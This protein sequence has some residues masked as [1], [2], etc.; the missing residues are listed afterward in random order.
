MATQWISPTWRM[1]ENSNQSKFENY[2]LSFDGANDYIQAATSSDAIIDFTNPWS[3]SWWAKWDYSPGFDCFWQFGSTTSPAR[4]ILAWAHSTGIGWSISNSAS[5]PIYYNIANGINDGNWHNIIFTGNGNTLVADPGRLNVYVDG[6]LNTDTPLETG[7]TSFSSTMNNI[8][9]GANTTNRYFNGSM[10]QLAIFDY[11]LG[12]DQV[13]DL[14]AS[15]TPVN[16]MSIAPSPIAYYPLGGGST[17]DAASSPSTLTVPNESVP[18]A[19]VFDFDGTNDFITIP[20]L[21]LGTTFTLS[22]WVNFDSFSA[23]TGIIFGGGPSSYA[24]YVPNSTTVWAYF[25]AGSSFAVPAL[26]GWNNLIFTRNGATGELFLNGQSQGTNTN[27]GTNNFELQFIGCENQSGGANQYYVDGKISNAAVWTSDQSANIAN[28]YNNGI[29]QSTYTTTPEAWWKLNVDEIWENVAQ[30]WRVKNN[31]ITPINYDRAG[32]SNLAY[33]GSYFNYVTTTNLTQSRTISLWIKYDINRQTGTLRVGFFN[34]PSLTFHTTGFREINQVSSGVVT[35]TVPGINVSDGGWHHILLHT[36]GD[37]ADASNIA[38]IDGQLATRS[39]I[40]TNSYTFG[41][42]GVGYS[43]KGGNLP[44]AAYSFSNLV[45]YNGDATSNVNA[46]Y[47]NGTPPADVS[48]TTPDVWWKT[49]STNSSVTTLEDF[50]GNNNDST[51]TY[52]QPVNM[53]T[54]NWIAE[55]GISSGMTTANLVTSDLTR[56]IPYSSYSMYMTGGTDD[57]YFDLGTDIVV[58]TS[59]NTTYSWS[60]WVRPVYDSIT[61]VVVFGD[62]GATDDG[63]LVLCYSAGNWLAKLEQ[64]GTDLKSSSSIVD[65]TWN[66]ISIVVDST[67]STKKMYINGQEDTA[68]GGT[69]A[70]PDGTIKNINSSNTSNQYTGYISNWAF[71]TSALSDDNILSI[72]NNGAPNS[73]T[74]LSPTHWWSMSGDSYFNGSVWTCPDLI[75]SND[76]T[77]VNDSGNELVGDGPGSTAN[78]I[79]TSMNIPGNLQGNAPN[80]TSNAFSI[81]MTAIDRVEDVAP[82][83]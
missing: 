16:P 13:D 19:T 53:V 39:V 5:V 20:S 34:N 37:S 23:T 11:Q 69:G 15:G 1:P 66:H 12:S 67:A 27:Y 74:S 51:T 65:N 78:G 79:A 52:T 58:G 50:S 21:D 75:G 6:V 68:S 82:T 14:Y 44:P 64:T 48:S 49:N 81:N 35:F 7:L 3:I 55:S 47:N 31:Q 18:S 36:T 10:D 45:M 42:P 29:P 46:L 32:Q 72:Y 43:N 54:D 77:G 2:N 8:G 30:Q 76:L 26:S 63:S 25:G 24:L 83:P 56:S 57:T 70:G 22:C 9:R 60:V 4:Y 33:G 41:N 40:G 17:G 28:I 62:S 71:W 61:D 38:Y 59:G 80:S 73:L